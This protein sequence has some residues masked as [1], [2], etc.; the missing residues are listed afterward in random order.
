MKESG[1]YFMVC[2]GNYLFQ[3]L[4]SQD[5]HLWVSSDPWLSDDKLIISNFEERRQFSTGTEDEAEK[6]KLE[7]AGASISTYSIAM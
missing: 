3:S 7:T 2:T 6:S 4:R 1:I 5:Y